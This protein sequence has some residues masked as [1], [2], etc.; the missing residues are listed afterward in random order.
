M[1]YQDMPLETFEPWSQKVAN[2]AE[3]EGFSVRFSK[4]GSIHGYQ[5]LVCGPG[6]VYD[7]NRS[8]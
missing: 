6:N 7:Y 8:M 3:S 5:Q 1:K 2:G 4:R